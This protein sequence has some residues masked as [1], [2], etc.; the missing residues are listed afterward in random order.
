[1]RN[2]EVAQLFEDV[3]DMLE[4]QGESGFRVR[5]YREG[6]RQ[7]AGLPEPIE[8]V[9]AAGKLQNIP[10]V[11]KAIAQKIDE[12]LRTGKLSYY[13][14]LREQVP[15]GL[16]ALLQVPGLGPRTAQLLHKELGVESLDDLRAALAAH[17]VR[18]VPGL[19]EKTEEK[20]AREVER[21][22]ES[23]RRLPL[24]VAR[25]VAEQVMA[26]LREH[27]AVVQIEPGG[28]LR[29]WRDSV[30]DLDLLAASPDP[31]A[32]MAAFVA[33]PFVREVLSRGPTFT[34]VLRTDGLGVD[35][36]VVKPEFW[37][38]ALHHFTGSR[39]HSIRLRDLANEKGLKLNEY[40]I[41]RM[42]TG[43]RLPG[44]T[45]E[46]VYAAVGLPWI[47]PELREDRGEIE[48]ALAGRLPNLIEQRDLRGDLHLHTNWSDGSAP[49][50][51]MVEAAR[52]LG[53]E[54]LVITD[55]S[56]GLGVANGLSVE[57]LW[58]QRQ[59]I[60]RLNK[61]Y[62]PFHVLQGI[63]MEI[64]A[65]GSLDYPDAVLRELDVVS[66]SLHSN[67]RQ[68][69]ERV[70]A[71]ELAAVEHPLTD[72]LNH[73]TGR[74]VEKRPG[75]EVDLEAVLRAAARTGTAVEVNGTPERLDLDDV[76]ARRAT[77]LGVM[78]TISSD[79][80]S[81]EGLQSIRYGVMQARRGWVEARHVL[82]TR[83]YG[84]FRAWL[85][86]RAAAPSR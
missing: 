33:L 68:E 58:A 73:P 66:I 34:R 51:R 50:E 27:P 84:E 81:P 19:G 3:A 61:E 24:G 29:R 10:G 21:L 6:A 83:P 11:G 5:A 77:E 42:D 57:R 9:A 35:L 4:V 28:S 14:R 78:L 67:L 86:A 31:E 25:P 23:S 13:E 75:A 32:V 18:A 40:G 22:Q 76:W 85:A 54:Y 2:A 36:R 82:N 80:H 70:T 1:M 59:I 60:D 46:D 43:E 55:H 16:V 74:L 44:A 20:L 8:Q 65:D 7:I 52:A 69:P 39:A 53:Y 63:E 56:A 47:T 72:V 30:G 37:G 79:A 64:R 38:T 49:P 71:R 62:A 45:E 26:L 12:Y 48:A 17:R 15:P 41:F